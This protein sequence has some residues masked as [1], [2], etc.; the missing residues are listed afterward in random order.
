MLL[1]RTPISSLG[2]HFS[3]PD[4]SCRHST[5]R[6]YVWHRNV[7]ADLRFPAEHN[8]FVAKNNGVR[9]TEQF[10]YLSVWIVKETWF[11]EQG[12]VPSAQQAA[13]NTLTNAERSFCVTSR[14]TNRLLCSRVVCSSCSKCKT[15]LIGR[16]LC[17]FTD[18]KLCIVEL[19]G[20]G[21]QK[22][23]PSRARFVKLWFV[24]HHHFES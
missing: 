17:V 22:L 13:L 24:G 6:L 1:F 5:F 23:A 14:A 2:T 8:V 11:K 9:V 16:A 7:P 4:Q 10:L 21:L 18:I 19:R 3:S 12:Q 20:F 15:R